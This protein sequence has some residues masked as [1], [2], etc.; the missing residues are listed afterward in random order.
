MN[1]RHNVASADNKMNDP[2]EKRELM[3][4]TAKIIL[5]S[6]QNVTLC[7][8]SDFKGREGSEC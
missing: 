4:V 8:I 3:V 7:R 1:E 6:L 2:A 5:Q